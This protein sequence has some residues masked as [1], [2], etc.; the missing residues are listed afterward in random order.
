MKEYNLEA[1]AL[2]N[3]EQQFDPALTKG[4][5]IKVTVTKGNASATQ[6]KVAPTRK[7]DYPPRPDTFHLAIV[8]RHL[9]GY[10]MRIGRNEDIA[11]Q[12]M[13]S[14]QITGNFAG[15]M[16]FLQRIRKVSMR[17]ETRNGAMIQSSTDVKELVIYPESRKLSQNIAVSSKVESI[18]IPDEVTTVENGAM[19][20]MTNIAGQFRLPRDLETIGNNGMN[21]LFYVTR[22][23]ANQKLKT[24]GNNGLSSMS[25]LVDQFDI[26]S[27]LESVGTSAFAGWS[28]YTG[29]FHIPASLVSIG[30]GGFSENGGEGITFAQG[31][32]MTTIPRRAFYSWFRATGKLTIP[33]G[34]VNIGEQAFA[35]HVYR[36]ELELPTTLRTIESYGIGGWFN[37]TKFTFKSPVKMTMHIDAL[38]GADSSRISIYVPSSLVNAYKAD[39]AITSL[40]LEGRIFAI[41]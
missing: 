6:T 41:T 24:V 33:E 31:F 15:V 37:A 34:V 25:N 1:D 7:Y 11:V 2:G 14:S 23:I 22:L 8:G 20:G 29:N 17:G 12:G 18:I 39:P 5:R 13:L 3:F 36:S 26:P 35:D 40:A 32:S 21:A 30:D 28:R 19:S 9:D 4:E 38:R 16:D 27:T 10:H